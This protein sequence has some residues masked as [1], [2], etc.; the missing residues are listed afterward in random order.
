[1]GEAFIMGSAPWD[2][3][4]PEKTL[5]ALVTGANRY[6]PEARIASALTLGRR[7]L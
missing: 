4:P 1:V 2:P 6:A 5:F 3:L 7:T